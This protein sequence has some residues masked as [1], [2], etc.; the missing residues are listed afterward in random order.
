MH[1]TLETLSL[2]FILALELASILALG[3][4][5]EVAEMDTSF[6]NLY[7]DIYLYN[8][9]FYNRQNTLF[10]SSPY[11]LTFWFFFS[12]MALTLMAEILKD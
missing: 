2:A 1:L 10:G 12:T 3:T 8:G 11:C 9:F 6:S 4:N 5:I 7:W